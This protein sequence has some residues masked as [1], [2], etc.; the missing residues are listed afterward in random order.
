MEKPS[1]PKPWPPSDKRRKPR[2]PLLVLRV[3]LHD[4]ARTFFGYAKNISRSGLFI[5][6]ISPRDK[7]SQ[8]VVEIP[9]PNA[10]GVHL[11]CQSEVIWTRNFD[12]GSPYEPGMGMK[13]LD[14][15]EETAEAIERWTIQE[16]PPEDP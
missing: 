12:P 3:S 6:T 2:A 15:P 8:F 13:F 11:R 16:R 7:G 9:L 10:I 5:A 1:E 14:L 4:G